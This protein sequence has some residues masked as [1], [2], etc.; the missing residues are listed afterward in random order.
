MLLAPPLIPDPESARRQAEEELSR[1]IYHQG[2]S[3]W[4][5]LI[6]WLKD[7]LERLEMGGKYFGIP[8]PVVWALLIAVAVGIG[9]AVWKSRSFTHRA[10]AQRASATLFENDLPAERLRSLANDAAARGDWKTAVMERFR[11][12][13][14]EL[15]ER[16][17]IEEYPG[18]TAHAAAHLAGTGV[19]ALGPQFATASK[20]FDDVAYGYLVA[21][22]EHDAQL[23]LLEQAVLS[24]PA[25][26]GESK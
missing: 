6:E 10:N 26:F 23:R 20:L 5:A 17:I 7:L 4:D 25:T 19:P 18:L 2:T 22:P 24:L 12:I 14:R 11:S 9:L 8:A 1:G 3:L 21:L 15:D 13:I 16:L